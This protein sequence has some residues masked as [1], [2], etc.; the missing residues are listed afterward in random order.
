MTD[1]LGANL[2][3]LDIPCDIISGKEQALCL[4]QHMKI[5]PPL[6]GMDFIEGG[7]VEARKLKTVYNSEV[8]FDDTR[9]FD[10][11][12]IEVG[13]GKKEKIS[14]GNVLDCQSPGMEPRR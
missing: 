5:W 2:E 10:I 1:H 7:T 8:C 4:E 9:Q 12:R 14:I 11:R 6:V 3:R 13:L